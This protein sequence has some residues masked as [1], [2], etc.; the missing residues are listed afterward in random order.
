[1]NT[2]DHK[3]QLLGEIVLKPDYIHCAYLRLEEELPQLSKEALSALLTTQ[4][5]DAGFQVHKA[6]EKSRRES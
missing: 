6:I 2:S 5:A 1:M 4:L 3:P